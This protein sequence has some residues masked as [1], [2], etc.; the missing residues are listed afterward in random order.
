MVMYKY[1]DIDSFFTA[2]VLFRDDEVTGVASFDRKSKN[3]PSIFQSQPMM[4]K[5]CP[6]LKMQ[7]QK[8]RKT[9]NLVSLLITKCMQCHRIG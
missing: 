1:I 3:C 7:C 8:R 5:S 9:L 6:I 4:R 2:G